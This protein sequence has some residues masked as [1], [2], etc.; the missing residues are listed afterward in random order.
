[1]ENIEQ[2]AKT[3]YE[4]YTGYFNYGNPAIL[5]WTELNKQQRQKWIKTVN[6]ILT[7]IRIHEKT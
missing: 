3:A 4:T 6:A 5:H 1:M 2:L 7:E